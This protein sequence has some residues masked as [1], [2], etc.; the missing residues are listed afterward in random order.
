MTG[1]TPPKTPIRPN[2]AEW[3]LACTCDV[4]GKI[5]GKP[6]ACISHKKSHMTKEEKAKEKAKK[7]RTVSL[8]SPPT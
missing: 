3:V 8:P 1:E 6:S 4:C 7:K 5:L 2:T